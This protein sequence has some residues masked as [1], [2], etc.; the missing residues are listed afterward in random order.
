MPTESLQKIKELY[1][2]PSPKASNKANNHENSKFQ[3]AHKIEGI[4]IQS[5]Q[6]DLHNELD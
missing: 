4:G 6:A 2:L 5:G 3:T 1:E